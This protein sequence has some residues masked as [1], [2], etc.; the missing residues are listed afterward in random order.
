VRNTHP[1]GIFR[2]K[3]LSHYEHSRAKYSVSSNMPRQNTQS[4]GIFQSIEG[5]LVKKGEF[6]EGTH[7]A[8]GNHR[9]HADRMHKPL[10]LSD[11]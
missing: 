11:K 10:Y 5:G 6:R 4:V 2:Y 3:I 9:C 7:T 1:V 8:H